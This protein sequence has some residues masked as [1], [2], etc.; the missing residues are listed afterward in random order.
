MSNCEKVVLPVLVSYLSCALP[1]FAGLCQ[2]AV[3]CYARHLGM[4]RTAEVSRCL[5][6][7]HSASSELERMPVV[8]KQ[9]AFETYRCGRA[10]SSCTLVHMSFGEKANQC[11]SSSNP[12]CSPACRSWSNTK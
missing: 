8:I 7:C 4:C 5:F 1:A 3:Q 12:C 11:L 10:A 2:A 9:L 6:V